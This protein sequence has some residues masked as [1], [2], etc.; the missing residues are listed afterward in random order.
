MFNRRFLILTVLFMAKTVPMIFFMMAL[1][2]ILR[3]K[4]YSL[5]SIGLLQLTSAPYLLKF[6][7]A[8]AVDHNGL[9]ENHY[10]QWVLWTGLLCGILLLLLGN[11]ALNAKS[12]ALVILVLGISTVASTQDIAISALYIKLLSFHE[13][14]IGSSSKILAVNIASI[15]GSGFFLLLYNHYGWQNCISIMAAFTFA[16]LFPLP[17]L[18]EKNQPCQKPTKLRWTSIIG[19]FQRP[20]MKCWFALTIFNAVG[21]SA[22]FFMIKPLLVDKSVPTDTI[23]L[24]V[25]F[26]GMSIAAL[27]AILTGSKRF[28]WLLLRRRQTYISCIAFEILAVVFFIPVTLDIDWPALL[29]ISI[30]LLNIAI[31]LSSVVSGTLIMD[32]AR[33]G[34]EG[35]DYSLQM[36]GIHLGGLFMAAISGIIVASI[37]YA[38]FFAFQAFFCLLMTGVTAYLFRNSWITDATHEAPG[39]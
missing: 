23:A 17:L 7:W 25:G 37:G 26:Y 11:V 9:Q 33:K 15:L 29:Y 21:T 36:T 31:T 34:L 35:V 4:G 2:V 10:K 14:G 28:Q 20:G 32:F 39:H 19:F 6:L 8:P 18:E 22:V 30:A 1:P 5:E 16:A 27:T 38:T 12:P 13:R 3:L 24:L